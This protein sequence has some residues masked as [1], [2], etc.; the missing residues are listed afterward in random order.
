MSRYPKYGVE[1]A[2]YILTGLKL[3]VANRE[4]L[5]G[6]L[7]IRDFIRW[8]SSEFCRHELSFGHGFATALDE[9]RYLTLHTL[10]LPPDWPDSYLD[11]VLTTLEREA[12]I[13]RLRERVTTRQPA[14]YLTRESWFCGLK[15]YV[16]ERV[17]VPRSPIAELIS[18]HFEPWVDSG[19]VHKILDLYRQWLYC[20][21]QSVYV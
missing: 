3:N 9:A 19:Q 15:F 20:Y 11:S 7:T 8:A 5:K 12:V 17:L 18:A 2:H 6:L 4:S 21:C 16:D 14:A 13:D 1:S 10:S